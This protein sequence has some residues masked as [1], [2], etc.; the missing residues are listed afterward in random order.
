MNAA[1]ARI[2]RSSTGVPLSR[3]GITTSGL[4]V[5]SISRRR[6]LPRRRWR[7]TL[8]EPPV[9]PA[10]PP[11]NMSAKSASSSSGR[12][13]REVGARHTRRRH[14]RDRLERRR[15]APLPRPRRCRMPQ[16]IA[17]SATDAP[18]TSATYS[19][20]SSSRASTRGRRRTTA[21]YMSAKFAPA[22]TMKSARIHCAAARERR[23]R[24]GLRREA[25]GRHRREGVRE[26]LVRRHQVV[27]ADDP[28]R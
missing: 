5:W 18:T 13:E 1:I 15:A 6:T 4:S 7:T 17:V 19:R 22:M 21:R 12:P 3:I 2:V 25:A 24:V 14:D 27:D 28:E 16:S 10:E 23:G 11:T 26:R 9:E 20:N 8:I